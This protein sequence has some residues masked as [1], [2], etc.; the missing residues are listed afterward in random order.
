ML[1]HHEL[2]VSE[3]TLEELSRTLIAMLHYP[4][5]D[6]DQVVFFLRRV[7]TTVVPAELP[8]D[9]CRD[10]ED[11]PVLGTAVAGQCALLVSVD[12]DLLDVKTIQDIP[13]V[14]PGEFWCRTAE[15]T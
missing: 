7:G 2:V 8:A 5:R 12:R 4:R 14:R 11:I 3:Y 9:S 15:E 6:A 13:I 1:L 10:A